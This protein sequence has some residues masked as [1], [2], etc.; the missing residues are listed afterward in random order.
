MYTRPRREFGRQ[1]KFSD[2]SAELCVDLAP[3]PIEKEY[4][5]HR[6]PC[7][8]GVTTGPDLSE[9]ECNTETFETE[10]RGMNHMEGGWP[11]DINPQEAEQVHYETIV[12]IVVPM[13]YIWNALP[14]LYV[15]AERLVS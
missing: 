11:K 3:N 12:P 15:S 2:S 5:V 13:V 14:C 6:N 7:D 8:G 4:M 10:C 9:H 1:P